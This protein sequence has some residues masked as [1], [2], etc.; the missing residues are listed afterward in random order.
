[1]T[2]IIS[3]FI[4]GIGRVYVSPI[5]L[6]QYLDSYGFLLGGH[7]ITRHK[8]LAFLYH[9][10][11]HGE[12]IVDLDCLSLKFGNNVQKDGYIEVVSSTELSLL[13]EHRK[14]LLS[15]QLM[16]HMM[17]GQPC[18]VDSGISIAQVY[19]WSNQ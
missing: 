8:S 13:M 9:D 15:R 16:N 19:D 11:N 12:H 4:E 7:N 3:T 2:Q 5:H 1:M 14:N 17:I 18:R 6:R 10:L